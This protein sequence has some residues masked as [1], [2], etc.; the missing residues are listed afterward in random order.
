MAKLKKKFR[1][2]NLFIVIKIIVTKNQRQKGVA[3]QII[4]KFYIT[5]V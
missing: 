3:T 1:K 5:N 2:Y 4:I